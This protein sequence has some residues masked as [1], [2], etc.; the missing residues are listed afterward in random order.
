MGK[1]QRFDRCEAFKS[2]G[3][4]NLILSRLLSYW[5]ELSESFSSAITP[6]PLVG[7]QEFVNFELKSNQF[8]FVPKGVFMASVKIYND[9]GIVFTCTFVVANT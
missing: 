4:K 7:H 1:C 6:C 3:A 9:D 8:T 5:K 2:K